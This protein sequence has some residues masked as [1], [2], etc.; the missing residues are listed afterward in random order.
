MENKV[1]LMW[2]L[3]TVREVYAKDFSSIPCFDLMINNWMELLKNADSSRIQP[4]ISSYRGEGSEETYVHSIVFPNDSEFEFEWD[5]VRAIEWFNKRN[6][7]KK[8]LS[9]A[10]ISPFM[11]DN[12]ISFDDPSKKTHQHPI[13]VVNTSLYG[14]ECIVIN[15]NHRIKE[16]ELAGRPTVQGFYLKN[17]RHRE[18]MTSEEMTL[19]YEFLIDHRR[20]EKALE[21]IE[22]GHAF[23]NEELYES[24][25]VAKRLKEGGI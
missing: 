16:S 17:D 15:G 21:G 24:L 22:Q 5:I 3:N 6:I 18:W 9:V 2:H 8:N 19:Y 11:K 13:I 4:A 20:L 14:Q 10:S 1:D 12:D 7:T 25:Q 23:D